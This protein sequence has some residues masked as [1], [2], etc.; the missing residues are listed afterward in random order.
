[1]SD[2]LKRTVTV[3]TEVTRADGSQPI[4]LNIIICN[5]G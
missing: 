5:G 4:S 2:F 3:S 1:M